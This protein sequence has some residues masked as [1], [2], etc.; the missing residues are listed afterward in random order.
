MITPRHETNVP[1]SENTDKQT[2]LPDPV[3]AALPEFVP[4]ESIPVEAASS[5]SAMPLVVPAAEPISTADAK[6]QVIKSEALPPEASEGEGPEPG[7]AKVDVQSAPADDGE[8]TAATEESPGLFGGPKIHDL[9]CLHDMRVDEGRTLVHL[10]WAGWGVLRA[11]A[12]LDGQTFEWRLVCGWPRDHAIDLLVPVGAMLT[13]NVRNLWGS[14]Q[15]SLQVL[16]S[17]PALPLT[18]VPPTPDVT[19]VRMLPP[20]L[21]SFP[22]TAITQLIPAQ[23][24]VAVRLR[25]P[26]PSAGNQ[27]RHAIAVESTR[28]SDLP[29]LL[30]GRQRYERQRLSPRYPHPPLSPDYRSL[31]L[32]DANMVPVR[33]RLK[34]WMVEIHHGDDE[35]EGG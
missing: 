26:L 22:S 9:L 25:Q 10:R 6:I 8:K 4:S 27:L 29:W 32:A 3:N 31:Q 17:E 21:P 13:V 16:A 35:T 2:A 14:D 33:D 23:L 7:W 12:V 19:G 5:Q 34:A 20:R 18:V 15:R 1:A 24:R 30:G 11:D 28:L